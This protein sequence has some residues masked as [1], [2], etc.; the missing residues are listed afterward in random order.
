VPDMSHPEF[1]ENLSESK[2]LGKP[3]K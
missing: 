1:S 3:E 2:E